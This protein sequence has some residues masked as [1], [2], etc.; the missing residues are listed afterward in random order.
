MNHKLFV[1]Y[2]DKHG[3]IQRR[4]CHH[5]I[6]GY[7]RAYLHEAGS[8]DSFF[9]VPTNHIFSINPLPEGGVREP[10]SSKP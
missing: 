10:N 4:T 9:T 1:Q 2:R 6:F 7:D 8:I 3:K 5:V